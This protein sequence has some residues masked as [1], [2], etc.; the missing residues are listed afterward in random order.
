M[1]LRIPGHGW[2]PHGHVSSDGPEHG[3]PPFSSSFMLRVR[4]LLPP[5][6]ISE[7]E[8]HGDHF[9]HWQSTLIE[10]AKCFKLINKLRFLWYDAGYSPPSTQF[11][12][13]LFFSNYTGYCE[14]WLLII[15]IYSLLLIFYLYDNNLLSWILL[16]FLL[17]EYVCITNRAIRKESFCL[18]V[19]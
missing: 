9:S 12:L 15:N 3:K 16:I 10:V 2:T 8:D 1:L 18:N 14:R 13:L 4:V 6:Q 11:L 19:C 7:H 5:P 17:A